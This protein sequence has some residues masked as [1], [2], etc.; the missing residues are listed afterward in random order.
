MGRPSKFDCIDMDQVR[1]LVEYGHDDKF[2]ASFFGIT[3]RTWNN[4][5]KDH[6][7]FFQSLKDWKATADEHVERALFEKARGYSHPEDK[8]F[9]NGLVI[10]T[11]KHYPPDTTAAIF[12]LKNRQV[13][14]WR[15]KQEVDHTTKGDK[16]SSPQ[17]VSYDAETRQLIEKTLNR[18]KQK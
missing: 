9:G 11:V 4:W 12:W 18:K 6:P 14:R 15:D 13:E 5:K 16:L 8:I 10:E 2:C 17:I 3:E 1:K 7:D